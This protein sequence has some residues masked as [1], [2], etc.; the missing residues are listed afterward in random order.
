M[1]K[2]STLATIPTIETERLTLRPFSQDD[3]AS[4]HEV[5]GQEGVL[6]YFPNQNPPALDRVEKFIEAQINHWQ[7]H[8]FGW[9]AVN[10]KKPDMEALPEAGKFTLIGWNGLQYLPDTDEV[11]VGYL[12]A[13]PFWGCG[14][15]AEGA[16]PAL[17]MAFEQLNLDEVVG[18]V[19]PENAASM[20]VL[21]KIGMRLTREA[22]YFGMPVRRYAIRREDYA[23]GE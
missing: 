1:N 7:E 20:R 18:I 6:R 2:K 3:C 23:P 15:A 12:L 17:R 21:E 19:H 4:L 22:E 16:Q 5:L 11:E 10:L 8:G 13:L 9:W 14:L